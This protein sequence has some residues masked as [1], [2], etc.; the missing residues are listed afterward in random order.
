MIQIATY[1]LMGIAGIL[2]VIAIILAHA[3]VKARADA[4]ETD[5]YDGRGF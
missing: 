5:P 1:A 4:D 3:Y 2:F